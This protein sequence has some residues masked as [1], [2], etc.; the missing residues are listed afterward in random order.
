VRLMY[1][2]TFDLRYGRPEDY[3][4]VY[5]W[6]HRSGGYRY[7]QFQDG[8]WGRLPTTSVVAPLVG[9]DIVDARKHFSKLLRSWGIVPSHIAVTEV[10]H[11]VWSERRPTD[12]VP[13]YAK[14]QTT[15]GVGA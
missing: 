3:D 8:R 10:S 7:F 11:A 15:I 2:I 5:R 9:S 14:E 12:S 4:Q 1:F 13:D 6:A